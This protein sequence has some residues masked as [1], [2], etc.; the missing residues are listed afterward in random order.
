MKRLASSN[1]SLPVRGCNA[2]AE[3]LAHT[4]EE[5]R[6]LRMLRGIGKGSGSGVRPVRECSLVAARERDVRCG[7]LRAPLVPPD[8]RRSGYLLATRVAL[9]S[10]VG[11]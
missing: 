9:S 7:H 3:R 4:V 2:G 5:F 10:S 1:S 6:L 11:G 8:E